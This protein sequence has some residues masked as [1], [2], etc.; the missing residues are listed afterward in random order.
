MN[1]KKTV[2][3]LLFKVFLVQLL[4]TTL[5]ADNEWI[6]Y[7]N[8]PPNATISTVKD[9]ILDRNITKFTGSGIDNGYRLNLSDKNISK[10]DKVIK[11]SMR[12]NEY[13]I[14][15][16][17]IETT[18]GKKRLYYTPDDKSYGGDKNSTYIH[19]GLGS[20]T[21]DGKWRT[22]SR[23]IEADLKRFDSNNSLISIKS[24]SVRG[25]GEIDTVN[26]YKEPK[27]RVLILYDTAGKYGY[28]GKIYSI[29]LKNLLGHFDIN[30]TAKPANE[31]KSNDLKDKT[32]LFYLGTTYNAIDYYDKNSS[33][34]LSYKN[35]YRDIMST[36]KTIVW[37]NY[38]LWSLEK[39]WVDNNIGETTF[40]ERYGFSFRDISQLKYNRIVYKN[41]ELYKGVV[42]YAISGA[43][44]DN[45]IL[46]E[47]RRYA[48]AL[49]LNR[50]SILNLDRVD[51]L[52]K[53]YSTLSE[54][55]NSDTYI[56]NSDNFWFVGD[57]PFTYMSEED[58]YLA[59]ADLL[60]DMVK[61][62]HNEIQRAIMRLEDVDARTSLDNLNSLANYMMSKNIKFSVATIPI[63]KDPLGVEN[64]GISITE[65]ISN[66]AIG[67]R[68]KELYDIGAIDIVQHGTTHQYSTIDSSISDIPNP[69]NG[70]SGS[71]FE[72]MRVIRNSNLSY[73]Y[74]YPI[75]ND[76]KEWAKS[77][78]MEGKNI[79]NDI[80][81]E[82]FA[83][84]APHYM[85][86]ANH[87][88]AIRD[89]YPIQYA[90]MIYYPNENNT[91]QQNRFIGQFYPYII[92]KDLYGYTIIPENIHNTVDNP[93]DGFRKLLPKDTIRFAKKLK[94]VRDG[95]AS[96][97][98]H[99]YLKRDYLKEVVEGLE[100]EGYTFVSAPSLV[101]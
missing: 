52:A 7:D 94:V 83:W 65:D 13:Y 93:N 72:F 45:C 95:V 6:V 68:L 40:K 63:Y 62:P 98:Y 41:T 31:Y 9:D 28:I 48:C 10:K 53:A 71:D 75:E 47:N 35:F 64:S 91:T 58:R 15:Y 11:W 37:I 29:L 66:S 20:F 92:K 46:E 57:I 50:V 33:K 25:S 97:Y 86:G 30:I 77:R 44:I 1:Y 4:F 84:E 70:V 99:P 5:Y 73:S 26:I 49:E 42:P 69:Y 19:F 32:T 85:A 34:R 21:K 38:N 100:R 79:L 54:N 14:I 67:S 8:I 80:G 36:H 56:I 88:R 51:I 22:F 27:K 61:I 2:L 60:H 90:R 3:S 43:I 101:K 81:I 39:Y 87:Y 76:S 55:N 82:A 59:F 24:F 17:E 23:D 96:F 12:Y 89:I 16:V 74:L 78:I 18:K